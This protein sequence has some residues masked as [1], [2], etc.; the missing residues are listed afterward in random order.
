MT[1]AS[2]AI[3]YAYGADTADWG[4]IQQQIQ[5]CQAYAARHQLQVLEVVSDAKW[6][7]PAR[8]RPAFRR[9][10]ATLTSMPIPPA[11]LL[12]TTID[13]IG[14]RMDPEEEGA[15]AWHLQHVGMRMIDVDYSDLPPQR[16]GET[17]QSSANRLRYRQWAEYLQTLTCLRYNEID[18]NEAAMLE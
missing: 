16:W 13:R 10:F 2:T 14:R 4:G 1:H 18:R 15:L 12:V 9:L 8:T 6:A 7:G 5:R 17:W 11:Y 3:I